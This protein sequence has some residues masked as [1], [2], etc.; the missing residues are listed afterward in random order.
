MMMFQKN[1]SK[2]YTLTEILI[3]FSIFLLCISIFLFSVSPTSQHFKQSHFIEQLRK[4]IQFAK[5][6]S[7]S[8]AATVRVIFTPAEN[9]Y[10]VLTGV[11]HF[12]VQ[13]SYDD[14]IQMSNSNLRQFYFLPNGTVSDFGSFELI[15]GG[16]R[17]R[18]VMYVGRGRVKIEKM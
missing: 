8:R 16:T 4:D 14:D 10:A 7:M 11:D 12:L 1:S 2:G 9:K 17:Y 18:F 15:V 5:T 3:V 6:Y 13:R